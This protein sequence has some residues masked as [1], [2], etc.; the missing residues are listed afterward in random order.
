M[1]QGELRGLQWSSL[2]WLTQSVA[3]RHSRDDYNGV[4]VPPK[5][6]RTRHIPLDIDVYTS[7]HRRKGDTGYVFLKPDGQPFNNDRMNNAIRRLYRQAGLRKIGWH[8]LRHTFASH[9][10]MRGVPMPVIK[11]LLGHATITTTMRYAHVAPSALRTAIDMLNPT[12]LVNPDFRQPAVLA[13]NTE[14]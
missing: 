1:R 10:A 6:G 5:N 11:E 3:V 4:L 14:E 7:L 2:N 13:R 8:T 12:T 9:L